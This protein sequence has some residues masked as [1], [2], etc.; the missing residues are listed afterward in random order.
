MANLNAGV[1]GA[2]STK[3]GGLQE[4]GGKQDWSTTRRQGSR[5][6]HSIQS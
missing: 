5:V 1:C 4:I 2:D 3:G 6:R